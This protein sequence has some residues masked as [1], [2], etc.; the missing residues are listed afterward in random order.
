MV[1]N[2]KII[3]NQK[4]LHDKD[5]RIAALKKLMV[6]YKEITET[7]R[8]PFII[9]DDMLCVVTANAAFYHTFK[10]RKGETEGKLIYKLGDNQWDAPGLRVLLE[11]ILP[12][13]RV[14][15]GYEM[16]H[17]FPS[18][19]HKTLLL[20]ARQVDNKQLILLAIEDVTLQRKLAIDTD[21]M[22][23]NLT[24]QRDLLQ[25]LNDTK[26]EFIAMA[27]HQLRT[28]ATAVKQYV[29]MVTEGYAGSLAK[30]QKELLDVAYKNN[31]R[32]LEIIEDLLRVAKVDG[33]K[34][35]LERSLCDVVPQVRKAMHEQAILFENRGQ[36]VVLNLAHKKIFAFI[37]PKLMLM[38]IENLLDNAAKYS[39]NGSTVTITIGQDDISTT[40]SFSDTGVGVR[41]SDMEKLFK[42][43]S[44]IDNKLSDEARGTGL[45][46]YWVKKIVGLHGGSV[47]VVSKINKGSTFTINIPVA[48]TI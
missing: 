5:K 9:L 27:S 16:S 33:G 47:G 6:Y 46:L 22:T 23:T 25:G 14:M 38:V 24:K 30:G 7:V 42:K 32:Q 12:N 28:P 18:L 17:S 36:S 11:H 44:R 39:S 2:E 19:G 48:A 43:F 40:I 13:H 15:S 8:E 3:K 34:V 35:S 20:N 29:G 10:V 21:K 1:L 45:G 26:D 37:D 31:E 4:K 41:K